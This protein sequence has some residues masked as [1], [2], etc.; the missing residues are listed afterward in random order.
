MAKIS[1]KCHFKCFRNCFATSIREKPTTP[2]AASNATFEINY[3][4]AKCL[5]CEKNWLRPLAIIRHDIDLK[6]I[7]NALANYAI[8]WMGI[9]TITR[10]WN[11]FL[12]SRSLRPS[13]SRDAIPSNRRK[14]LNTKFPR[15][16]YFKV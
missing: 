12:G 5:K 2:Y 16:S 14:Q 9:K 3:E 11:V 15:F 10:R 13:T 1:I 7:Y 8:N 4:A 6:I